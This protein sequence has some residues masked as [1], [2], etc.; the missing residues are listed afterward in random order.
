MSPSSLAL[1]RAERDIRLQRPAFGLAGNRGAYT[2]RA[3]LAPRWVRGAVP[4]ALAVACHGALLTG[5]PRPAW[6]QPSQKG[7]VTSLILKGSEL[8]DDQQ[9]EESIQTLSAALVRPGTSQQDKIEIYRLLA[10][11]YITLKRTEEADAAVRGIFVLDETFKLPATESPRFRDFF[12]ATRSKWE[13][14]GKPGKAE[15]G[16]TAATEKPIKMVHA[17]PAQVEPGTAVKL[18]GTIEDP[19]ARVRGIQLNYRTGSKGKF[20]SAVGAYSMGQFRA[21]IPSS[22]VKPPLVEYYLE[23]LDKGGLP[24]TSRGDAATP[25]RIAVPEPQ[26]SSVFT[27]P[28]FWIP[29]GVVLVG[30]A[31]VTALIVSNASNTSTVSVK[32]RE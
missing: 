6:A 17:S 13:A 11:N 16:G 30:G 1:V 32:V 21:S 15:T 31:V 26:S 22:A 27:S 18:T 12:E 5:A 10:Y 19:D 7:G 28:F 23:A 2:L 14:E 20:V 29:V 25:L 9:Y 3:M 24:L 8:F 4:L